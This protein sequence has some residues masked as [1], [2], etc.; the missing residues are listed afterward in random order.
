VVKLIINLFDIVKSH[1]IIFDQN[2]VL[3]SIQQTLIDSAD[4][5]K[6]NNNDIKKCVAY[7][8][9]NFL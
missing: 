3:E 5:Q 6:Q 1:E 2:D 7:P 4:V 8:Q 9:L